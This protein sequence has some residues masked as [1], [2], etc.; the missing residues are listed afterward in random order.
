MQKPSRSSRGRRREE[1]RIGRRDTLGAGFGKIWELGRV[2]RSSLTGPAC[3]EWCLPAL[4]RIVYPRHI[5]EKDRLGA[6]KALCQKLGCT[7]CNRPVFKVRAHVLVASR[8]EVRSAIAPPVSLPGDT[9]AAPRCRVNGSSRRCKADK[10]FV[11]GRRR[12]ARARRYGLNSCAVT[13]DAW[14]RRL[15]NQQPKSATKRI[16]TFS[17]QLGIALAPDLGLVGIDIQTQRAVLLTE[18]VSFE[19]LLPRCSPSR[20]DCQENA[21]RL[22]R[23]NIRQSTQSARIP[24]HPE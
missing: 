16:C 6:A 7:S 10:S 24:T 9:G 14:L 5:A 15:A 11:V 23:A 18:S 2:P 19:N 3:C 21:A 20:P 13:S 17:C 12:R 1:F 8:G 22:C 4:A